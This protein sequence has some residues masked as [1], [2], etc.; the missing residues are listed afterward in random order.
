MSSEKS[1]RQT[2][3]DVTVGE[4]AIKRFDGQKQSRYELM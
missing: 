1:K 4:A 2:D 3:I